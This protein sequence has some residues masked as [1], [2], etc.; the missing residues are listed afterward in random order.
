[1]LCLVSLQSSSIPHPSCIPWCSLC[2]RTTGLHSTAPQTP[3]PCFYGAWH[4]PFPPPVSLS[5]YP[6]AQLCLLPFQF[7]IHLSLHGEACAVPRRGQAILSCCLLSLVPPVLTAPLRL[8][9]YACGYD[10]SI[11]SLYPR[12]KAL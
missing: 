10:D 9:L 6:F 12:S 8:S 4:M 2:S 1:M 11:V 3:L 7:S 5:H